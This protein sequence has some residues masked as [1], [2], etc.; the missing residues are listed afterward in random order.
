VI[1][2]FSARVIPSFHL[3]YARLRELNPRLIMVS[4]PSRGTVGPFITDLS[5]GAME[6]LPRGRR[7]VYTSI[8]PFGLDGPHAEWVW[9]EIT[10]EALAGVMAVV[11]DPDRPPLKVGGAQAQYLGGLNAAVGT[12][13]ALE[14]RDRTGLGQVVDISMQESL[15][16]VLGNIPLLYSHLGVVA[17]RIGSRHHRTHPTTI[18]PCK[19]G[20][21]GIAAQTHPQWEALCLLLDRP[22]IL[23]DSRFTTGVQRAENADALDALLL[24]WF[25][26]R[27]RDEVMHA[28]QCRRIPVGSSCTIPELLEDPQ[29]AA[30]EFFTQVEHPK[31]GPAAYPGLAFRMDSIAPTSIRAPLLGEH[32]DLIYGGWLGLSRQECVRLRA[33]GVI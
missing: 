6:A 2:N 17:R 21:V 14:D 22:E 18:F 26:A 30:S 31:T 29:F 19:D 4:M 10:V 8:R 27:T 13:L 11:G 5:L 16:T 33:Q 28:C 20:F 24:P 15:L 1:E 3:D 25:M 9:T 32:N 12:L 23:L 7:L